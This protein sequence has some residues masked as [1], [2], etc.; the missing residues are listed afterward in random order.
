MATRHAFGGGIADW[1][2]TAGVGDVATLEP[3]STITFFNAETAGTQYTDLLDNAG[4]AATFIVSSNGSDGRTIGQVPAFSGP[5]YIGSMWASADGGPR[6]LMV[7][8][9]VPTVAF[10]TAD[11]LAAHIAAPN[12]HSVALSQLSDT[13]ITAPANGEV[14]AYETASSKWKNIGGSGLNPADFVKTAGGSTIQVAN[15]DVATQSLRVRIPAG[16]RSA[17]PD[18]LEMQYNIGTDGAPDWQRTGYFNEYG[19]IRS[20]ASA[21]N[22]VAARF[23]R[24]S[25]SAT[26][27]ILEVTTEGNVVLFAAGP[28]GY[29]TAPN[30]SKTIT[31][32]KSGNL[33]TGAGTF[34][35][36]NDTGITL[37]I[38]SVR[39]TVG[40]APSGTSI[41]VD[42]HK[43]GT[44]IFTTQGNRPTVAIAGNTSGKVTNMN[45]TTIADGEYF[46]VDI[47]QIG[48]GTPGADLVVQLDVA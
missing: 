1:S 34:R 22:R 23:Q 36:Y 10:Q 4:A 7:A 42:I 2:F 41:I 37:V 15:G 29:V 32:S 31:F 43:S 16:D 5:P 25:G 26:A 20:R 24:R 17:A 9:D 46:T 19:E 21:N 44:T 3:G 18:T 30:V 35:I 28:A 48:S 13:V 33:A 6:A 39:A 14:L 40:T 45:V 38:R 11:D 12:P 27:N 47:D 8:N